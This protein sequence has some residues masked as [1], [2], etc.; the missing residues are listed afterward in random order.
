MGVYCN[1]ELGIQ[2]KIALALGIVIVMKFD[3]YN[4]MAAFEFF[5][6]AMFAMKGE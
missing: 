2:I 4:G 5:I 3:Y 6:V 1:W